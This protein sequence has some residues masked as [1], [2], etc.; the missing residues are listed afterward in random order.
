MFAMVSLTIVSCDYDEDYTPPNYVTF[1][2]TQGSIGVEAGESGSF[3]VVVYSANVVGEDRTLDVVVSES[4]TLPADSY[5]VPAT[6]TIPANSNE[7][8]L[9]VEV[10]DQNIDLAGDTVIFEILPAGDLSTGESFVLNVRENCPVGTA[11]A[12]VSLTFDSYASEISWEVVDDQGAVVMSGGG[13]ADG[14]ESAFKIGCLTAGDYDFNAY[15]VYGDGLASGEITLSANGTELVLV[16]GDFGTGTTVPF[17][18][19]EVR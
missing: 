9:T 8:V 19:S 4:S 2:S 16:E 10:T 1:A 3:D 7:A 13:Y 6:V 5:S 15:D 12:I 14:D 17:T 18:I 11:E